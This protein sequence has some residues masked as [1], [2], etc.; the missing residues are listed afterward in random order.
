MIAFEE[1][2]SLYQEN[3]DLVIG[4]VGQGGQDSVYSLD[5]TWDFKKSEEV[6]N[7]TLNED[8]LFQA[9]IPI[10]FTLMSADRAFFINIRSAKGEAVCKNLKGSLQD[11]LLN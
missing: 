8:N 6:T 5:L 4:V 3:M 9:T 10:L 7:C 11:M 2:K 1:L